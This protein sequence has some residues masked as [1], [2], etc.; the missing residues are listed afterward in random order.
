MMPE[1]MIGHFNWPHDEVVRDEIDANWVYSVVYT[2]RAGSHVRPLQ[3]MIGK[4]RNVPSLIQYS[5]TIECSYIVHA[6]CVRINDAD[7]YECLV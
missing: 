6:K 1:L 2:K 4:W 5:P 7:E 3:K